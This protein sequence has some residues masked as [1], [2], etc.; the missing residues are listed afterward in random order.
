MAADHYEKGTMDISDHMKGWKGFTTF[1][2]LSLAGIGLIM[3]FLA[4]FRTHG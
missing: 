4:I 1:V 2:K 3:V